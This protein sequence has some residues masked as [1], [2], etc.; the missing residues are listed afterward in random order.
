MVI[1]VLDH[2]PHCYTSQDG[3]VIASLIRDEF[4]QGKKVIVSFNGVGDVPS[5]FVNAAFTSLLDKYG[6]AFI[7]KHLSIV[8][9][10]WQINDMIRRRFH[11]EKE[12]IC[13]A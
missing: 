1:N 5:S 3:E 8:D 11:L 2:V 13:V 9:S 4:T 6:F 12:K 10:T 7:K